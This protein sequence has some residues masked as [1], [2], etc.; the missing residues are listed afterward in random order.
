MH[1]IDREAVEK[2]YTLENSQETERRIRDI[3]SGSGIET[4]KVVDTVK[5]VVSTHSLD[6]FNRKRELSKQQALDKTL[7]ILSH[8]PAT[9][10][11]EIAEKIGKSRQTVYDYFDELEA[12]GKLHRN[13]S[14]NVVG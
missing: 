1:Q 10:P 11:S 6:R 2:L 13:G 4:P 5:S 8:N 14:I 9:S 12:A 3:K 7:Q